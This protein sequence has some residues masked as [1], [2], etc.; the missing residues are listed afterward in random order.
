MTAKTSDAHHLK[1]DSL[2]QGVVVL[3]V[4]TV[5]QRLI[6]FLRGVFFCRWLDSSQLGQWDLAF[7]F[8]MM[9]AP[10]V[11]L[12][13]PGTFGRYVEHYRQQGH[14]KTFLRRISFCTIFTAVPTCLAMAMGGKWFSVLI[15]GSA[16]HIGLTLLLSAGLAI[17]VAYNF[18]LSLFTALRNY[19]VVSRMQFSNTVVFAAGGVALLM[20]WRDDPSSVVIAFG[21][22]CVVST[23]A[24]MV[25]LARLWMQL[26]REEVPLPQRTLWSKL[27]PFAFW[28]WVTNWFANLFEVCDRF[29]IV[30]YSGLGPEAGLEM[31]GQYHTARLLPMLMVGVA[32]LLA[33][34]ITPH[35]SA[36]W[37]AGRREQVAERL[38]LIGKS[39]GLLVV[40]GA[41]TVEILSPLLFHVALADKYAGGL[42]VLPWTLVQCC[43]TAVTLISYNYLW[44]VEKARL[45]SVSVFF[46]LVINVALNLLLLPRFGLLGAA[47][48]A[49]GARL[50]NLLLMGWFVRWHGM[51]L[52]RGLLLITALPL[53]LPLGPWITLAAVVAFG[54]G[55]VPGLRIFN[56]RES[57]LIAA[58]MRQFAGRFG[59]RFPAANQPSQIKTS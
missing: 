10:L 4:L 19:R 11:A 46:G 12:G 35:L 18:F 50:T 29:M 49:S 16:E 58:T 25:A 8:L 36:D 3:L 22:A 30:H 5:V 27:A 42:A 41:V 28:L 48:A 15:F 13:L 39:L 9:A 20:F 53:L 51:P 38:T 31:V 33:T 23:I 2:A 44:C 52:D 7:G 32:D 56:E 21:G 6:G 37:E 47:I 45:A 55:L 14:L 40:A 34:T 24:A 54:P 26:P 43:W 57:A 59:W 17:V 1:T